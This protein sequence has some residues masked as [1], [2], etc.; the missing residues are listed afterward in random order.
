VVLEA[1][2]ARSTHDLIHSIGGLALREGYGFLVDGDSSVVPLKHATIAR[3]R[4]AGG[5]AIEAEEGAHMSIQHTIVAFSANGISGSNLVQVRYSD[6]HVNPGRTRLEGG[7][8]EGD[9]IIDADPRFVNLGLSPA[10][11]ERD[12]GDFALQEGSPCID[13]G[14]E[15][16]D[17]VDE[18]PDDNGLCVLDLGH[19]GGTDQAQHN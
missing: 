12:N 18:P 16:A 17:C 7:V 1:S 9:G 5:W 15:D 4:G 11:E 2:S 6:I 13:A 8:L 3:I 10:P 14:D 19:L